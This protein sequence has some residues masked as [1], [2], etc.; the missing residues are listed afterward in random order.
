MSQAQATTTAVTVRA[1]TQADLAAIQ[2]IHSQAV[3]ETTATW[4]EEPWPWEQRLHWFQEHEADP[5][6]PVFVAEVGGEVAGF[7]YLSWYRPKVGYRFTREDTVYVDPAFHRKGVGRLLVGRVVEAARELGLHSL[8]A[9]IEAENVASI[10]LH[11]AHG[12]AVVGTERETGYKF[13]RF[14]SATYMQLMLE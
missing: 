13:G 12:F 8:I 11:R 10:E 2:R 4:D 5:T 7:S 6:T 3:L 9:A 1:A 14:L